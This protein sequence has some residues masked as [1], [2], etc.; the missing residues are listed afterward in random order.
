LHQGISANKYGKVAQTNYERNH[1]HIKSSK[2][3]SMSF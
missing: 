1:S 3:R 2:K